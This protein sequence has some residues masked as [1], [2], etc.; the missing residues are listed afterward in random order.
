MNEGGTYYPKAK[1]KPNA[2]QND[3]FYATTSFKSEIPM[4]YFSWAE[5]KISNPA[6][7]FD[8][9]IKGASFL[10][11]NCNSKSDR[12][13]LVKALLQTQLRIDALSGCFHNAE[14]PPGMD[15]SNSTQVQQHYLFYFAV[16]AHRY[17]ETTQRI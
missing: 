1:V 10:A 2:Y 4:P 5:Y 6:V 14:P 12:E 16:S 17:F 3:Q 11:N 9:A 15:L 7:E 8:K 13:S